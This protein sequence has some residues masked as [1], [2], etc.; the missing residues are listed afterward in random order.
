MSFSNM[1]DDVIELLNYFW[2]LINSAKHPLSA[3]YQ[4]YVAKFIQEK[5]VIYQKKNKTYHQNNFQGIPFFC[6]S[7]ELIYEVQI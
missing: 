2:K 1:I 5:G 6:S 7:R 4:I 3:S